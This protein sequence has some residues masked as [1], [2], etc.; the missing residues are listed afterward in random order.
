[1]ITTLELTLLV[2]SLLALWYWLTCL[3]ESRQERAALKAAGKNGAMKLIT[4][5]EI[6]Q[7]GW[8]VAIAATVAAWAVLLLCL[9][10]DT[11]LVAISGKIVLLIIVVGTA[12]VG[13]FN[14]RL[15]KRVRAIVMRLE[16]ES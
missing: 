3:Q 14:A 7:D 5:A 9:S 11:G 10:T 2:C 16:D 12:G 8:L 13:W 6:L 15:R 1:M 4:D